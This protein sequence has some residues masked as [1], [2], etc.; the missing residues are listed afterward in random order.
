MTCEN[1]KNQTIILLQVIRLKKTNVHAN[2][3]LISF[4]N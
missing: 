4:I 2:V 1:M 3:E